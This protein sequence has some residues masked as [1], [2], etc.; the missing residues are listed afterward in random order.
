MSTDP[1]P[2]IK[3]QALLDGW[4][5]HDDI[6]PE[7]FTVFQQFK[8]LLHSPDSRM[9]ALNQLDNAIGQDGATLRSK[10][11]LVSLRRR[12][13]QTHEQMLKAGR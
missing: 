9:Q 1:H 5:E 6:H 13:S 7:A 10:S 2:S 4:G 3:H 11:Q 12:L 8:A